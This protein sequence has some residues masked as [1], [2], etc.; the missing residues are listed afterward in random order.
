MRR[1]LSLHDRAVAA[2]FLPSIAREVLLEDGVP[3]LKGYPLLSA[4]QAVTLVRAAR[5]YQQAVWIADDDPSLA[6]LHLVAAVEAAAGHWAAG[7]S[8]PRDILRLARPRLAKILESAGGQELFLQVA[9]EMAHLFKSTAKFADFLIT[10]LPQPP[11][12]RPAEFFQVNWAEDQMR[13]SSVTIYDWRS[14]ALHEG[15]Q[16]PDPMC[17][18][19]MDHGD[20]PAFEEHPSGLAAGGSG[21]TWLAEDMPLSLHTFAY[22]VRGALLR[23][24]TAMAE[25]SREA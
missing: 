21:G 16:F 10:F 3:M 7:Q 8:V 11:D 13:R 20:P 19:P 14:K 9:R 24:W 1:I 23:W 2:S 18:P 22:I 12:R 4:T 6:W 17:W 25:A 5:N 15:V